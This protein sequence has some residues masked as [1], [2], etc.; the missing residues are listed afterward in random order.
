MTTDAAAALIA[1]PGGKQIVAI[2]VTEANYA[3][4][5]LRFLSDTR[6][7]HLKI[8]QGWDPHL[9][10]RCCEGPSSTPA[11]DSDAASRAGRCRSR[12]INTCTSWR[13]PSEASGT[14]LPCA[15]CRDGLFQAMQDDPAKFADLQR[16]KFMM[17]LGHPLTGTVA[18]EQFDPVLKAL[19]RSAATADRDRLA[20]SLNLMEDGPFQPGLAASSMYA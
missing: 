10:R 14:K 19:P 20:R 9:A 16:A 7:K 12:F 1:G 11:D 2:K 17:G 8:V 3:T 15:S 4:S 6:L 18:P 13:R 5:T